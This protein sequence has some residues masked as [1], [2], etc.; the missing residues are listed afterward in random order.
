L[1]RKRPTRHAATATLRGG[2]DRALAAHG[3]QALPVTWPD[4]DEQLVEQ[5]R[6]I[7]RRR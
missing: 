1:S 3:I 6:A 2:P 5:L 7:L 4:L